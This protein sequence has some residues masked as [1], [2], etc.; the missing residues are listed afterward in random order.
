MVAFDCV[1]VEVILD[2]FT[3]HKNKLIQI[4]FYAIRMRKQLKAKKKMKQ[5]KAHRICN[6]MQG[7]VFKKKNARIVVV[8]FDRK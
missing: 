1:I 6:I 3:V 5:R 8:M 2:R 4:C 7:N